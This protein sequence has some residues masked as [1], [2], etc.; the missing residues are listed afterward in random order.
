[1]L[2]ILLSASGC[3]D[4]G[5]FPPA[6]PPQAE[7]PAEAPPSKFFINSEDRAILAVY[8]HLLSLAES[9]EAKNYLA[10][11][12]AASDN[13]NA[14]SEL[15]K[16]GSSLWYVTV[17][18]SGVADWQENP[19]WQVAGWFVYQD[20]RVV[21]SNRLEANALRI[22]ADLQELSLQPAPSEDQDG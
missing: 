12:S 17:D 13:W 18:M 1:L 20:A 5:V 16:D 19:Y 22:E 14:E 3:E 7:E 10:E 21:P 8:E 11:F 4:F 6:E 9:H 15:F 2:A